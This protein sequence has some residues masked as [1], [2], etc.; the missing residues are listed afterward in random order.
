MDN[1][2]VPQRLIDIIHWS[3]LGSCLSEERYPFISGFCQYDLAYRFYDHLF[4]TLIMLEGDEFFFIYCATEI[5][6]VLLFQISG[7]YVFSVLCLPYTEIPRLT[8]AFR[9][10]AIPEI[11]LIH[12]GEKRHSGVQHADVD[13]LPPSFLFFHSEG[14][15][16]TD[17][18]M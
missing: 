6:P 16:N 13:I 12:A 8:P 17:H 11:A 2:R 7:A 14:K 1:L 10:N 4:L 3:H 18:G 9:Y 5:G 15:K